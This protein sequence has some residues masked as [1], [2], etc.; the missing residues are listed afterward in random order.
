MP[1][2]LL[3]T[4][5]LDVIRPAIVLQ[6]FDFF[7]GE[8]ISGRDVGVALGLEGVFSV[9]REGIEFALGHL[10]D[11]TFQVVHA[12]DGPAADVVLPGTDFEVGPVGD[13]HAGDDD[14]AFVAKE[15]VTEEL[16]QTLGGIK[17]SCVGGSFKTDK[18]VVDGETVGLIFV[19]AH[20]EVISLDEFDEMLAFD[21]TARKLHL[22]AADLFQVAAPHRDD[23]ADFGI[24]GV[25]GQ[26]DVII[27]NEMTLLDFDLL[28]SG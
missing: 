20:A 2:T 16:F 27:P 7:C 13:G 23:L 26:D 8:G 3:V 6:L 19:L 15:G 25:I 5:D 12:D 1:E 24:G 22:L 14:F 17:E 11:E 4:D 10:W 9:K 28:G 21:D 18:V